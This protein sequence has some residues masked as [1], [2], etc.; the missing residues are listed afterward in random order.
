VDDWLPGLMA[1]SGNDGSRIR[2]VRLLDHTSG[3]HSY[4]DDETFWRKKFSADFLQHRYETWT[5]RRIVRL[6]MSHRP[7]FAPGD[8]WIY[9]DDVTELNPSFA[10]TAGQM[11]FDNRD[12][13]VLPGPALR[14]APGETAAGEDDDDRVGRGRACRTSPGATTTASGA[15]SR[16]PWQR[17]TVI[18]CCR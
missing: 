3:I 5:P 2:L 11:I 6:A 4:T 16:R 18:T 1:G 17:R 15:P 9:G 12:P 7:A 8:G 10:G 14:P 13:P